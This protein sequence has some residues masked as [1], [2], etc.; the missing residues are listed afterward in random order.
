M[1]FE[2]NEEKYQKNLEKH[3]LSFADAQQVFMS[4]TVT[5]LDERRDYGER[6]YVTLGTLLEIVVLLVHTPRGKNLRMI[7]MRKANEKER[8][9]YF[10]RLTEATLSVRC[11]YRL[12]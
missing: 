1:S 4:S 9:I 2:W 11:G 3:G 8:H 7:S 10:K 12:L 6:R 5:F